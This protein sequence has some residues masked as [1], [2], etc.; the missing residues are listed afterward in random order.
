MTMEKMPMP[1][2]QAV[3]KASSHK[4][5]F[6]YPL[7]A[8]CLAAV[9][10][11]PSSGE[12]QTGGAAKLRPDQERAIEAMLKDVEPSMRPMARQQ[13]ASSFAN[14]SEAQIAMMMSKMAENNTV[15]ANTPAPV[16]E[17]EQPST[18]EDIAFMKAQ[19]EPVI[20]KHHGVQK[21]FD[22]FV[23]AKLPA[24]CP[25]RDTYARFG[26]AWRYEQGQFMMDSALATWNVETNVT[27]AGEAYAPQSGRY[28]FD[29]SKVRMTFDKPKIDA[30]IKTAC[31]K[32]H[33]AGKAFLAKVDPLI[34]AK[35]WDAAFKAEQSAMAALEPIR[36]ELQ[37]AYDR[38]GPG[39]FTE[40]QLAMM[41]GV[42]VK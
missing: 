27:V 25:G 13:L 1:S 6:L 15:K 31:D 4:M 19:Y 28:K 35:N 24:Y 21:D 23:N 5:R 40:I 41:N 10:L 11:S 8:V 30:A 36:K 29:F 37:A 39:D 22:A 16:V 33:V 14:F 42:K 20:R 9:F 7:A 2:T 32:V 34:A 17:V 3:E 18:P 38:L 12:A 26:S